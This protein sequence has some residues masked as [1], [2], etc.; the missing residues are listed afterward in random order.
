M[1]PRKR[2]SSVPGPVSPVDVE[3]NVAP[4]ANRSGE[5]VT[6]ACKMPHG[7]IL[8]GF[9]KT[10]VQVP[11]LGGGFRDAMEYEPDG[12]RVTIFGNAAPQN[13][14]P[15]TRVVCGFAL[16]DGVDKDMWDEWLK[17]NQDLPAVK[18]GLVFAYSALAEAADAAKERGENLKSGFERIDPTGDPRTPR[19]QNAHVGGIEQFKAEAAA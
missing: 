6:V 18:N 14:A 17:A 3:V 8:R 11:V 16:T 5:T 1:A 4:D 9:R 19:R 7:L 13:G 2:A 10:T 15:R 12:R